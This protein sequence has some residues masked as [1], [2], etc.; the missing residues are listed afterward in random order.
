VSIVLRKRGLSSATALA[1]SV[2]KRLRL[3]ASAATSGEHQLLLPLADEDPLIDDEPD[4]A[5]G[6]P[7]LSDAREER[8]L[9]SM[10]AG[11]ARR[12]AGSESKLA[13]LLRLLRRIDE[14]AIVF[15]E[16]RDTL[17]RLE[18]AVG[19]AGKAV[20]VMH[21]GMTP[22]ERSRVQHAFNTGGLTLLATDA[23]AE[24][25]NLHHHCRVAI[26]YELPWSL[27]RLEQRTGRVDR[28]GQ[29]RRVH[30]IALV[31]TDTAERLV[32]A[33]LTA[34]A[35]R[36]RGRSK[37]RAHLVRAL[38]ESRLAGII[39]GGRA[40]AL[41]APVQTDCDE[42]P[43]VF[44]DMKGAA[45]A[46][47]VRLDS[48]RQWGSD[49]TTRT[50]G[51]GPSIARHR[52]RQRV[53]VRRLWLVFRIRLLD[54][55][56]EVHAET[57]TLGASIDGVMHRSRNAADLRFLHLPFL[58]RQDRSVAAAVDSACTRIANSV[59]LLYREAR[60][61]E[62]QRGVLVL[63]AHASAARALVQAGLFDTRWR[64]S[65]SRS[66]TDRTLA[67]PQPMPP[68]SQL[69]CIVEPVGALDIW[70]KRAGR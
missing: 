21:G 26:H 70:G 56:R 67:A 50:P 41:A 58:S 15:T 66:S 17:L 2:E 40:D 20:V 49:T 37:D 36:A 57:L 43:A 60:E 59:N 61:R 12:A 69:Q 9:L 18:Q 45:A 42:E 6:A 29:T 1:R 55:S 46:E 4:A 32:L 62:I 65:G 35:A 38:T 48:S 8:G 27:S 53:P 39:I 63:G 16:F 47:A 34:R 24:G 44:F 33:P 11:A 51:S 68:P 54:A 25:L 30:E 13:F 7:G 3:L 22:P 28:L 31:A 10:I 14:P 23:A 19:S 52:H 5:L 64:R